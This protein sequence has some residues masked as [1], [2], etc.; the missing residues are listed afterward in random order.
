MKGRHESY[1][2]SYR[3]KAHL[4]QADVAFLLGGTSGTSVSRHERGRRAPTVE[5]A[6]AYEVILGKSVGELYCRFLELLRIEIAKR[7]QLLLS[8]NAQLLANQRL[9]VSSAKRLGELRRIANERAN[10]E[11]EA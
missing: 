5:T 7:A 8:A 1:I 9:R 6:L 10:H 11:S 3:R 4:S 2:R